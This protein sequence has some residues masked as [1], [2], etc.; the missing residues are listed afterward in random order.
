MTDQNDSAGAKEYK[1]PAQAERDRLVRRAQLLLGDA[2]EAED[3]VQAT[4]LAVWQQV[5]SGRVNNEE[6]YLRRAVEWNA[7]KRRA[8]RRK[9]LTL[10]EVGEVMAP[11]DDTDDEPDIDLETLEAALDGLPQ[12]QQ[13]VIRMKYY[14]G[15]TF[16]EIAETLAISANTAASTC[17]YGLAAIRKKLIKTDRNKSSKETI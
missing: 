13:A 6:A 5:R 3:L 17:R 12:K 4:L 7:L 11:P 2:V 10:E 14:A 16:R 15:L 1:P 8:R 9:N